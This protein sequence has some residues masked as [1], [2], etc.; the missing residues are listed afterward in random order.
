MVG[1]FDGCDAA[2]HLA[3]LPKPW[4]TWDNIYSNNIRVDGNVFGE[5]VRVKLG[6]L[7]YGSTTHSQVRRPGKLPVI[8]SHECLAPPCSHPHAHPTHPNAYTRT[9][10]HTHT[11][12]HAH[13]RSPKVC[14][15]RWHPP[16]HAHACSR[17]SHSLT[18]IYVHVCTS[19]Q[20]ATRPH[21]SI[22]LLAAAAAARSEH[23]HHPGN[24]EGRGVWSPPTYPLASCSGC[25]MPPSPTRPTALPRY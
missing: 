25:K 5:A 20:A 17:C 12:A 19:T 11:H 22:L 6:R 24:A 23:A 13:K 15:R 1:L 14:A 18:R 4:E 7:V 9:W 2:V 16:M 21:P 10:T 3:A 8:L